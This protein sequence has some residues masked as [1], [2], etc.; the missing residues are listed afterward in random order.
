MIDVIVSKEFILSIGADRELNQ[1]RCAV[2][3]N[4]FSIPAQGLA[5]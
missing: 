2:Y 3:V 5:S 4:Q 1:H